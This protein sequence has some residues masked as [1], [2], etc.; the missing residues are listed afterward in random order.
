MSAFSDEL[1][2]I[3][4][5]LNEGGHVDCGMWGKLRNIW[6]EWIDKAETGGGA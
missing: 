1:P 6:F 5:C 2:C 4:H 3:G